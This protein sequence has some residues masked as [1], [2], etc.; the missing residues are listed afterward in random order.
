MDVL[1]QLLARQ[2]TFLV[3]ATLLGLPI[4]MWFARNLEPGVRIALSPAIGLAAS[5]CAF[6]T[7]QL[8]MPMSVAA[9]LVLAPWLVAS[10]TACLI[11]R[12]RLPRP[13]R[14]TVLQLVF[15]LVAVATVANWPLVARGSLGP[16]GYQIADANRYVAFDEAVREHRLSDGRR[17]DVIES[18]DL[19]LATWAEQSGDWQLVR[20]GTVTSAVASMFGWRSIDTQAAFS[21]FLMLVGALGSVAAARAFLPGGRHLAIL[22]GLSWCGPAFLQLLIDGSEALVGGLALFAPLLAVAHVALHEPSRRRLLVVALLAAGAHTMHPALLPVVLAAIAIVALGRIARRRGANVWVR[23]RPVLLVAVGSILLSPLAFVRNASFFRSIREAAVDPAAVG[24]LPNYLLPIEVLPGWLLQTREFYLLPRISDASVGDI[25][26]SLVAPALLSAVAVVGAIATRGAWLLVTATVVIASIA[27][28]AASTG[29]SY[30]EQRTLFPIVPVLAILLT[31]GVDRLRR[32]GRIGARLAAL[33][34]V[35][36]VV[37]VGHK[38]SVVVRRGVDGAYMVP[39]DAREVVAEIDHVDGGILLEGIGAGSTGPAVMEAASLY[40]LVNAHTKERL[41]IDPYG[42]GYGG[43]QYLEVGSMTRTAFDPAYA[44]VFTRL[45][46]VDVERLTVYRR[47]PFALQRRTRRTDVTVTSG[48]AVDRAERDRRGHATV[49]GPLTFVVTGEPGSNAHV[50]LTLRHDRPLEVTTPRGVKIVARS[51][52]SS[53]VC[54]PVARSDGRAT[55]TL[56]LDL[57]LVPTLGPVSTF[58]PGGVTS[59]VELL[60]MRVASAACDVRSL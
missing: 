50:E 58:G 13:D 26:L 44:W 24:Q 56:D 16:V 9:W 51:Q 21:I 14:S 57:P 19:T 43:L 25:A 3:V 5:T 53:M 60:G 20:G 46:Q 38:S 32:S 15:V 8:A 34:V 10:S 23:V 12:S 6:T 40:H 22:A 39:R 45:G 33:L 11:Y 17:N 59:G 49:Q 28:Y 55:A 47:G 7:L 4:V 31:L 37:M 35:G 30:C 42:N 48:V 52:S 29:C 27:S 1:L 2:G 36:L 41:S 18:D 54:V